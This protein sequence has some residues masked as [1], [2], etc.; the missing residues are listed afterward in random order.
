MNIIFFKCNE[1]KQCFQV[2]SAS[3]KFI[4]LKNA[5]HNL[6]NIHILENQVKK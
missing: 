6:K 4:N 2:K 3:S 5:L 1:K